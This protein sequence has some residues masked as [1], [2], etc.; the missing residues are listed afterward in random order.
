[1]ATIAEYNVI[2]GARF[3]EL[4]REAARSIRQFA[5]SVQQAGGSILSK[6]EGEVTVKELA[7][8]EPDVLLGKDYSRAQE[9]FRNVSKFKKVVDRRRSVAAAASAP[10]S[11]ALPVKPPRAQSSR[12]AD[13]QQT[14]AVPNPSLP[15]DAAGKGQDQNAEDGKLRVMIESIR[16]YIL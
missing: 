13:V 1:L 8:V 3:D 14:V 2:F 5:S 10:S 12:T 7:E 11:V 6:V 15:V 9:Q 16:N 4:F